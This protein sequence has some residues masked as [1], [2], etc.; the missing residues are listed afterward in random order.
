MDGRHSSTPGWQWAAA[1]AATALFVFRYGY[2]FGYSD[3]DEFLPLA[4]F[5]LNSDAFASDWFVAMQ[6]EGFSIRWPMAILVALPSTILPVWAVVLGWHLATAV[7]SSLAVVKLSHRVFG[8]VWSALASVLAVMVVT[9]R[10]NPGGNDILHAM[11]VPSSIAWC[12]ILWAVV[13]M[14]ERK[15]LASG[16][17]LALGALFHPLLGLQAGGLLLLIG[18]FL[19]KWPWSAWRKQAI[20]IGLVLIPLVIL[21]SSVGTST[22]EATYIL[23][24]VRAP[25]HYLPELFNVRTWVTFFALVLSAGVILGWDWQ[26]NARRAPSSGADI[27]GPLSRW[28]RSLLAKIM[29]V[30]TVVL[31]VSLTLTAWPFQWGTAVRLQPWAVS[32]LVRAISALV[33]AGAVASWLN[34]RWTSPVRS[35]TPRTSSALNIALPLLALV[36]LLMAFAGKGND[37][38]GVSSTNQ[39]LFEW[40]R[41]NANERAVFVIP[42]SMTGFQFGSQHA[43]YVSFKSFPFAPDPTLEWRQRLHEIAPTTDLPGGLALLARLDSAYDAQTVSDMRL[44]AAE[45]NVDYFVR[46]VDDPADWSATLQPEWCG[47]QWCVF[48]AGRILTQ[49]VRPPAS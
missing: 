45:A 39:E 29:I 40:S 11:L 26:P 7:G 17:L 41:E 18:F 36:A 46:P 13:R 22:E 35:D 16:A 8:N 14:H 38:K 33:I 20:P 27:Q 28:D 49:P 47:A 21:L 25:H 48:W 15:A 9:T 34:A 23:T 43:Q 42:P 5:L 4:S 2:G 12:L 37:I 19:P 31:L 6:I 30:P 24:Q 1:L 3:Q 44:F 10:W 32:P